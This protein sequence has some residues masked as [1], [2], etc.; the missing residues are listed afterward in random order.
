LDHEFDGIS[1]DDGNL[2]GCS[3]GLSFSRCGIEVSRNGGINSHDKV[4]VSIVGDGHEHTTSIVVWEDNST[5]G[6]WSFTRS[7]WSPYNFPVGSSGDCFFIEI[8]TNESG[9]EVSNTANRLQ[10]TNSCSSRIAIKLN[11]F[12]NFTPRVAVTESFEHV[13]VFQVLVNG[14]MVWFCYG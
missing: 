8:Y 6:P 5:S 2:A 14:S 9:M 3:N 7:V 11:F 13:S 12:G 1:F 10:M 4:S